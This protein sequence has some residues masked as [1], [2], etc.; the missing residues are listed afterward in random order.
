MPPPCPRLKLSLF[1][2]GRGPGGRAATRMSR[3]LPGMLLNHGASS[4]TAHS[5]EFS[6]LCESLTLSGVLSKLEPSA[7][8][9]PFVPCWH[10]A[11]FSQF[12]TPLSPVSHTPLLPFLTP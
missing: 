1:E 10:F 8:R 7:V 11:Q 3:D 2:T 9:H 6:E 4:F 5:P 12:K